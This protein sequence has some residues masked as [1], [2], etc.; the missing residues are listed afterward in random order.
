VLDQDG[1]RLLG[2]GG[3]RACYHVTSPAPFR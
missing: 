1:V 2:A 3:R